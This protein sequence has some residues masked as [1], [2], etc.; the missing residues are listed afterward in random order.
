MQSHYMALAAI[1]IGAVYIEKH[2]SL[3]PFADGANHSSSI[4][5]YEFR[6]M[7]SEG[8]SIHEALSHTAKAVLPR[9][10]TTGKLSE[11]RVRYQTWNNI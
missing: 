7:V 5:P 6:D 10:V 4:G 9:E 2:L 3:S 8:R 11:Y 1:A